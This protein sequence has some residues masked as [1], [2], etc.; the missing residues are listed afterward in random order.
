MGR[1]LEVVRARGL[2]ALPADPTTVGPYLSAHAGTLKVATLNRRIAAITAAHR[3]AGLGLDGG[4]PAIARVLAG[5]RRANGTRLQ[6]KTDILTEDLRRL[7]R[8][9]PATP[10]RG[11]G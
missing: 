10:G 7:V 2:P 3:I 11:P 5:I 1:L 6:A 4:H 8:A 9:L